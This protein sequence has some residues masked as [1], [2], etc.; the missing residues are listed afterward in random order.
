ME[1]VALTLLKTSYQVWSLL[2]VPL[3][4]LRL[5]QTPAQVEMDEYYEQIKMNM[6]NMSLAE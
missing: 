2:G 1:A 3:H 4:H 5:R 6:K